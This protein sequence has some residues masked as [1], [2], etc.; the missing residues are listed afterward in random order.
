MAT[1]LDKV[2]KREVLVHRKPFLVSLAPDG[3]KLVGKGRRK[4]PRALMGRPCPA[5]RHWPWHS[6]PRSRSA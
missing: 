4:R 3:L 1:K 2:L 5:I 6:T